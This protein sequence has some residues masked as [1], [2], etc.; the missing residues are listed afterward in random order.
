MSEVNPEKQFNRKFIR[1]DTRM[2][3]DFQ[4]ERGEKGVFGKGM[5]LDISGGGLKLMAT[6]HVKPATM[7]IVKT[8]FNDGTIE[9]SGKVVNAA[10]DWYIGDDGK[11]T[12]WTMGVQFGGLSAASRS[13]VIAYVHKRMADVREARLKRINPFR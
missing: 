8:N 9:L 4:Y 13:R 6:E 7:I 5:I 1:V 10:L 3:C 11:K 12:F 2:D